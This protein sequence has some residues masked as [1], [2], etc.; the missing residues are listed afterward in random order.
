ML[1]PRQ[2][3]TDATRRWGPQR[4]AGGDWGAPWEVPPAVG[5]KPAPSR[6]SGAGPFE[7]LGGDPKTLGTDPMTG[8]APLHEGPQ[9]VGWRP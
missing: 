4:G 9:A 2:A 6:S 8:T 1:P 5:V 3:P 7:T